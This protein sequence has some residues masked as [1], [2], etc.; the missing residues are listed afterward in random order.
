MTFQNELSGIKPAPK[1]PVV[2]SFNGFFYG[3]FIL[4]MKLFERT[5]MV[6]KFGRFAGVFLRADFYLVLGKFVPSWD[7][8]LYRL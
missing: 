4:Y 1:W 6:P 8:G 5:M 7:S 3:F 2:T